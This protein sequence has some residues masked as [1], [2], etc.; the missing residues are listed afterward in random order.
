MK[1]LELGRI[2]DE[3][4]DIAESERDEDLKLEMI[5]EQLI[6]NLDLDIED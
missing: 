2:V 4:M 1:R 3:I 5:C 6:D